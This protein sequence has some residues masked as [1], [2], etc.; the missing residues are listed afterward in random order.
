MIARGKKSTVFVVAVARELAGFIW[1]IGQQIVSGWFSSCGFL[2]SRF[3]SEHVA[4]EQTLVSQ[5]AS[6]IRYVSV[7]DRL[8]YTGWGKLIF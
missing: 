4:L 8:G 3:R 5:G 6:R 2:I 7:L 1:P